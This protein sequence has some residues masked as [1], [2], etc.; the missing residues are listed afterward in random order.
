MTIADL[1]II[2][3]ADV[4]VGHAVGAAGTLRHDRADRVHRC[5]RAAHPRP[6]TPLGI[7]PSKEV[8]KVLD[9]VTLVLVLLS[10]ASRVG[11]HHLRADMG[12]CLR[13]LRTGPPLTSGLGTLA[14]LT[15]PGVSNT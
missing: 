8:V 1:A 12:L 13:L 3:G 14:A 4:R 9:E 5:G 11:L 10:D 15:L 2:A 6:L 7:T